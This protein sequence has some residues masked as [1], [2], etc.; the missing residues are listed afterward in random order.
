MLSLGLSAAAAFSGAG[1]D[2]IAFD[3]GGDAPN[4]KH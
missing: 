3:F 4:R 2:K 1:A